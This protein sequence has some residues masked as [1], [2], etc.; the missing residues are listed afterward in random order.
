[1]G[2]VPMFPVPMFPHCV[3]DAGEIRSWAT[4]LQV[5]KV[6]KPLGVLL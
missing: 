1:M 2:T 4:D 6:C 5:S 3:L